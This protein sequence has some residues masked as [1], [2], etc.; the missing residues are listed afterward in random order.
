MKK[1]HAHVN[2]S[3]VIFESQRMTETLTN[4]ILSLRVSRIHNA[5]WNPRQNVDLQ[6]SEGLSGDMS[7]CFCHQPFDKGETDH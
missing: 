6:L 1:V 4:E 7:A 2:L 5:D 3:N